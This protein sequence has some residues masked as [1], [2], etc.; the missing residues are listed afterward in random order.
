MTDDSGSNLLEGFVLSSSFSAYGERLSHTGTADSA[1]AYTGNWTDAI[2]G[3]VYLRA[4]D[5]DPRTGQFLTVDPALD[6]THQPYAYVANDP[7]LLTDPTGLEFWAD[8]GNNAFAFGA[9]LLDGATFGASSL[10]LGAL[11]PG[12][13]CLTQNN[14]FFTAG[15]IVGTIASS[16]AITALTAGAGGGLVAAGIAAR[17]G[18]KEVARIAVFVGREALT[19]LAKRAGGRV[20]VNV[21]E[22]ESVATVARQES[23]L[24]NL[25]TP[26]RTAQILD[27]E[28]RPDGSFSAGHRAGTGY[29]G[30]SEFPATWSDARIMHNI[31]DVA[32]DPAS[33]FEVGSLG[34]IARGTREGVDIRVVMRNDEIITGYPTNMPRNP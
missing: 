25:A 6:R 15:S 10:I 20:G 26:S 31:S 18:I 29:N 12:Y 24:V 28:R 21:A 1:I 7:L 16:I 22:S 30:K 14:P 27:G 3:L 8:F 34:A 19:S 32:T 11:V 33:S 5:F 4:R 13:N 9:G 2:T 23:E 17:I